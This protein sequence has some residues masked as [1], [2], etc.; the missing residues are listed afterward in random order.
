VKFKYHRFGHRVFKVLAENSLKLFSSKISQEFF[1]VPI[2]DHIK[3]GYS[4]TAILAKE[5]QNSNL[6]PL[7]GVMRA[8]NGVSYAGKS[9]MYRINNPRN[10]IYTGP[11]GVDIILVDDILTTGITMNEAEEAVEK[12]SSE[13]CLKVVLSDLKA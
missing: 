9:L 8:S 10:F 4:H 2:D 5:M 7:Y 6:K 3:K 11:S 12:S 13:V 1:L